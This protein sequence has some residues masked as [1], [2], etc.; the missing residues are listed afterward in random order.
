MRSSL[1]VYFSIKQLYKHSV[2][3]GLQSTLLH[4]QMLKYLL[5]V[6]YVNFNLINIRFTAIN[7]KVAVNFGID[8]ISKRGS[9]LIINASTNLDD[10]LFDFFRG[11]TQPVS[12]GL[13]VPGRLTNFRKVRL[14]SIKSYYLHKAIIKEYTRSEFLG[15]INMRAR[16]LMNRVFNPIQYRR[17][18]SRHVLNLITMPKFC[19]ITDSTLS[20]VAVNESFILGLP[21]FTIVDSGSELTNVT[22]PIPG[23]STSLSSLLLY[24]TLARSLIQQGMFK[25]RYLFLLD[26]VRSKHG[27]GFLNLPKTNK[28]TSIAVDNNIKSSDR[29]PNL[30]KQTLQVKFSNL[31]K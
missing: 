31:L 28:I 14:Q 9:M 12:R 1:S 10:F 22:Y 11:F 19:F 24:Y 30:I 13:W 21:S 23:N 6:R 3:L 7:L 25:E 18:V 5:P 16:N 26:S 2:H 29:T 27:V 8:L 17:S 15:Q 4:S 20:Q